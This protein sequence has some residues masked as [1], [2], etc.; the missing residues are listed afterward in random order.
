MEKL[1]ELAAKVQCTLDLEFNPHKGMYESAERYF[2]NLDLFGSELLEQVDLSKDIWVL[3][4][5]FRTPIGFHYLVSNDLDRL[6]EEAL[7]IDVV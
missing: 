2:R 5:Y 6:V 1:V 7:K 4:V 3:R